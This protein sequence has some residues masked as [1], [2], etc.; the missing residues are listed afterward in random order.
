MATS[1]LRRVSRAR[2]TSPMPPAPIAP[3]ISYGPMRVLGVS[4]MRSLLKQHGGRHGKV[5][6]RI[7]PRAARAQDAG[8][9]HLHAGLHE[10]VVDLVAVD[11]SVREAGERPDDTLIGKQ[12]AE[13]IDE[14]AARAHR[15]ER[16]VGFPD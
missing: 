8:A 5:I 4:G 13:G 10:D 11:L 1:R 9:Q 16:G 2:Y 3:M 7:A 14:R 15:R 12:R 6:R